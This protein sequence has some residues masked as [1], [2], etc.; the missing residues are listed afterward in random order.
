MEPRAG[1]RAQLVA[2]CCALWQQHAACT[3]ARVLTRVRR[4]S[5]SF[6]RTPYGC[7]VAGVGHP[8]SKNLKVVLSQ[9]GPHGYLIHAK[10]GAVRA[11]RIARNCAHR[12]IMLAKVR[13]VLSQPS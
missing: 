8:A 6:V 1:S 11:V 2:S 4:F 7:R 9:N 5:V 3:H 13:G 12:W 10:K